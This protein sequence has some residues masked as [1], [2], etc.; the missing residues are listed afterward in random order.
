MGV[1]LWRRLWLFC[2]G[3]LMGLT[4]GNGGAIM[5]LMGAQIGATEGVEGGAIAPQQGAYPCPICGKVFRDR[6]GMA[7]H[8]AGRHGASAAPLK[9]SLADRLK[10]LEDT[11]KG[12]QSHI[13]GRFEVLAKSL[14]SGMNANFNRLIAAL[15][16]E[17]HPTAYHA[18]P[19][20]L[21]KGNIRH[22]PPP[23]PLTY[24]RPK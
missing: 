21:C 11:Y 22:P 12:L 4:R 7:G 1:G 9:G 5:G 20:V 8:L 18:K 13:D 14:D 23:P 3:A 2:P 17:G 24:E 10:G 6:R 19:I 16:K 15:V